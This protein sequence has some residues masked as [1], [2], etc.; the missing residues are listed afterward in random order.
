VGADRL[1]G[2]DPHPA[3]RH[4]G[5]SFRRL[6]H[7]R[8]R[9]CPAAL[10]VGV[11]V[12]ASRVVAAAR[13]AC[14]ARSGDGGDRRHPGVLDRLRRLAREPRSGLRPVSRAHPARGCRR[15]CRGSARLASGRHPEGDGSPGDPLA[16]LR[17]SGRHRG[18]RVGRGHGV[19]PVVG[20][21]RRAGRG[22]RGNHPRREAA[23]NRRNRPALGPLGATAVGFL[24]PPISGDTVGILFSA[25][26]GALWTPI[27]AFFGVAVG[28]A[29]VSAPVWVLLQRR[30][31]T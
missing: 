4:R 24:A 5:L 10:R 22:R 11:G 1:P 30:Q 26:V 19:V 16:G 18:D 29:A 2:G 14:R 27:I 9:R 12:R 21:R 20:G 7:R 13:P 17:L 25:Q 31:S 23:R 15:S 3:A 28:A 6:R 8:L